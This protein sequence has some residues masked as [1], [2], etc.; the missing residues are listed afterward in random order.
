[1]ESDELV[2]TNFT[3][4]DLI[5]FYNLEKLAYEIWKTSAVPEQW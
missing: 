4:S 3:S 1:M 2:L 5:E